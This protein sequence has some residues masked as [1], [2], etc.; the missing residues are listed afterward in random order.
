M[1]HTQTTIDIQA[2]H[3][4][5]WAAVCDIEH[6]SEWTPTVI[7][8]RP[9]DPGPLAVGSRA[10]VRPPKLLPA[11]W[12]ITE[13]EEGRGFS[14]IT[15]GPGI[16]VT[17]RHTIEGAANGSRATLSLDFSGALGPLCAPLTRGLTARYLAI[18]ARRLKKRAEAQARLQ[19]SKVGS[20]GGSR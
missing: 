20:A 5:V 3:D 7:S 1:K 17:A 10:I 6:W 8:V 11:R 15:R 12:Q 19:T 9:L 16:S 4:R 2:P 18:E 14:W 13:L